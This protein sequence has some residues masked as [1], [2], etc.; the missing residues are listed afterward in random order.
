LSRKSSAG[1][2]KPAE[3]GRRNIRAG[4]MKRSPFI[5]KNCKRREKT[6]YVVRIS[7]NKEIER[8]FYFSYREVYLNDKEAVNDFEREFSFF[9]GINGTNVLFRIETTEVL[10]PLF[11]GV[12][13]LIPPKKA[14]FSQL[15]SQT[16]S[17]K[18]SLL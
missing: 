3:A 8:T 5:I 6:H 12:L 16:N 14:I 10:T 17:I 9:T 18:F 11:L 13:C 1:D 4:F 15:L 7:L 2:G